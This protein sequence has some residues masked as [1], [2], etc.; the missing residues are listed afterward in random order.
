[1]SI[2]ERALE[3]LQ[4]ESNQRRSGDRPLPTVAPPPVTQPA[5]APVI[6]YAD[7]PPVAIDRERLC[8]EGL[9]PPDT[10]ARGVLN[11]YRRIKRPLLA[12]A[13]GQVAEV[14]E[15]GNLLMITSAVPGEGK[16]TT[17]IA[18]ALS[19]ADEPDRRTLLV[20]A[21]VA[22]PHVSRVLGI[23]K[24]PGLLD[25]L[26]DPALDVGT[27]IC[28]TTNEKLDVL[29]AGAGSALATELLASG[30][31]TALIERLGKLYR[32]DIVVLDSPPLIATSEAPVIA[33]VVGQ[34]LV[35][36]R[37][38]STHRD[39]LKQALSLLDPQKAVGLVLNVAP[40]AIEAAYY[41]YTESKY[42]DTPAA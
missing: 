35:V 21:D 17:A 10:V 15:R 13:S 7:G 20:D 22:K 27:L 19:F 12:L 11:Q 3:R 41:G 29:P 16:T 8:A 36:V 6:R 4:R 38:N 33:S 26:Q 34:I 14:A 1:M 40:S 25:A 37:A 32:Q 39:S 18:L 28:R 24:R 42:G 31:M 23:E 5:V 2:L 9:L 30:R